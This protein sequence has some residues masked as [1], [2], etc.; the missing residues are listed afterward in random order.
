MIK[1]FITTK[2]PRTTRLV[3]SINPMSS[4]ILA[5]MQAQEFARAPRW[6][7]SFD[8]SLFP[9]LT[10]L[11][12]P[13]NSLLANY[14]ESQ[15]SYRLNLFAFRI[16]LGNIEISGLVSPQPLTVSASFKIV[17][18]LP[19][20]IF[21]FCFVE[22]VVSSSAYSSIEECCLAFLPV[23]VFFASWHFPYM[24]H[25]PIKR[26]YPVWKNSIYVIFSTLFSI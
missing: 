17:L 22:E 5:L 3:S 9:W 13:M 19:L 12:H 21:F 7:N 8:L 24:R 11:Q 15:T 4:S 16:L 18:W 1:G 26:V 10:Q 23:E 25:F 20:F 6:S 14:V 2:C